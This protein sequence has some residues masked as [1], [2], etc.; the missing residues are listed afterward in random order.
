MSKSQLFY[1]KN[2]LEKRQDLT[3]YLRQIRDGALRVIVR[4]Y[5]DIMIYIEN[6]S[7]IFYKGLVDENHS[8]ELTK[9]VIIYH[10][11][12]LAIARIESDEILSFICK[13]FYSDVLTYRICVSKKYRR[14]V[15]D[16]MLNN[17]CV[18]FYYNYLTNY[19]KKY[20]ITR[21]YCSFTE[22]ITKEFSEIHI[23]DTLDDGPLEI[24]T[25]FAEFD[26]NFIYL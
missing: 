3:G 1:V 12:V 5:P 9:Q 25:K 13:N 16:R 20:I 15:L 18:R 19:D 11:S 6:R 4:M 10:P 24:L 8:D 7:N 21:E 22:R 14:M 2:A 17:T 23:A 26:S